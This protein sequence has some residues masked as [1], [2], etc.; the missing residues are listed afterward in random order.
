MKKTSLL[1][2]VLIC[3]LTFFSC[4]KDEG[5]ISNH[6]G[7][8]S[9]NDSNNSNSGMTIVTFNPHVDCV[10][11]QVNFNNQTDEIIIDEL[12]LWYWAMDALAVPDTIKMTIMDDSNVLV[13]DLPL[14]GTL[15]PM[16]PNTFYGYKLICS[17]G[18]FVND[19]L[20][21]EFA[22]L[23]PTPIV[24][25]DSA[26][27]AKGMVTCFATSSTYDHAIFDDLQSHL[28]LFWGEVED[29]ITND[30]ELDDEIKIDSVFSSDSVSIHFSGGIPLASFSTIW[31][32]AVVDDSWGHT[33]ESE[34]CQFTSKPIS[35]IVS[36]ADMSHWDDNH[37]VILSGRAVS[38]AVDSILF[39]RGFC[40]SL[41]PDPTV[42]DFV[43]VS[44]E[45]YWGFY[46]CELQDLEPNTT[47]YYRSFLQVNDAEG[48]V[49]YSSACKNFTTGSSDPV[50][51]DPD[52]EPD[53]VSVMIKAS[54]D[55]S[56][57]PFIP[58]NSILMMAT[59]DGE[60]SLVTE[61]GF[62]WKAI[63]GNTEE[64]ITF[65]NCGDN[66]IGFTT[67][68]ANGEYAQ[69]IGL[70]PMMGIEFTDADF[71]SVFTVE[72][73]IGYL[74]RAYIKWGEG[75]ISYSSSAFAVNVDD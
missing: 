25:V 34:P 35:Q 17:D 11:Y 36:D 27:Y 8:S 1:F 64:P 18:L 73:G 6:G 3:L 33:V 70:L 63:D 41:S 65:D 9:S 20:M 50:D 23:D 37:S 66:I 75:K 7:S 48:E 26:T 53:A 59:V 39:Q 49:F 42:N 57:N 61:R 45:A 71:A 15:S 4:Q 52:P 67:A 43:V 28:H 51:P 55:H 72:N 46:S 54:Y 44:N 14:K 24:R 62:V 10:D 38:G 21:G 58:E 74:L 16:Q 40:Y 19:T 69:Y 47:Y 2:G 32:K 60:A 30:I 22:T 31:F 12:T 5:D 13:T 56:F 68:D 29:E